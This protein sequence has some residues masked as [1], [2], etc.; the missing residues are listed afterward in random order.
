VLDPAAVGALADRLDSDLVVVGADDPLVAGVVDGVTARGR[1]AFGPDAAAAR[2]EG[3]KKWMKDV[4][5]SAG[6]PTAGYRSFDAGGEAAALAFV[7]SLNA[8]YV[9]KTDGLAAGKGR[10]RYGIDRR[11]A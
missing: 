6:V 8:P 10:D 11:G 2:L 3:S 5:A 4:L 7:E 9:V 1:L